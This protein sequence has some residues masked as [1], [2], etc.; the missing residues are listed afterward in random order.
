MPQNPAPTALEW[1]H[2]R[3]TCRLRKAQPS[4][5]IWETIGTPQAL[6]LPAL[7]RVRLGGHVRLPCA[8][9]LRRASA[10]PDCTPQTAPTPTPLI[11]TLV[12]SGIRI[13]LGV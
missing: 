6:S 12:L 1:S 8:A 9:Q 7:Y 10:P 13:V 5:T 2:V 4:R 11:L 3:N